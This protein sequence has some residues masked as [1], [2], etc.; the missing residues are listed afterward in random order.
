[1]VLDVAGSKPVARPIFIHWETILMT[2][3]FS[4]VLNSDLLEILM[5]GPLIGDYRRI[6]IRPIES[7]NTVFYQITKLSET[8][9]FHSNFN[10]TDILPELVSLSKDFSN[11]LVRGRNEDVHLVRLGQK[12]KSS[13]LPPS[14]KISS[15]SHNIQKSGSFQAGVFYP[16]LHEL[17]F[18]DKNGTPYIGK[19]GKLTQIN[20]FIEIFKAHDSGALKTIVDMGCG[21]AY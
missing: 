5:T 14:K 7:K 21:S 3:D 4:S 18:I 9:S 16:F 2:Y 12:F 20:K 8:K 6:L 19:S 10:Q 15:P 11:I 13:K 17:G 1:M